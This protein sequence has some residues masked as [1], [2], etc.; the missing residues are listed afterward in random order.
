MLG[1]LRHPWLWQ[2]LGWV[3]VIGATVASLVPGPQLP[4]IPSSDKF[5]HAL[6]YAVLAVWFA[7]L[8][9]RARY[10]WIGALLFFMGLAIEWAQGA[11]ELGRQRDYRDVIANSLGIGVGL[12]LALC[13]V[14]DWARRV[15]EWAQRS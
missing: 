14:G 1:T 15:E 10:V 3:L 8:Y 5:L 9:P 7:G 13:W 2:A 11:M 6:T 12:A 4:Q